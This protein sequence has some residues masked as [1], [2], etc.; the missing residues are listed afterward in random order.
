MSFTWLIDGY[1]L[2]GALGLIQGKLGP[3]GL[4]KGRRF[5][6][7]FLARR[8]G[9]AASQVLVIFDA[10][11]PPR[12]FSAEQEH[13]GIRVIFAKEEP[14][15][16]DLIEALLAREGRNNY[17]LV[18]SDHRLHKA[19]ARRGVRCL[20]SAAFLDELDRPARAAPGAEGEAAKSEAAKSEPTPEETAYWMKQFSHLEKE[21]GFKDLF[22]RYGTDELGT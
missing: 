20:D 18:S 7:E 5:L 8:L 10:A 6:L 14:E 13:Q 21:P 2:M 19:A 11:H 3:S 12:R 1:N 4:E 9:A 15:A 16:D 17:T 22:E